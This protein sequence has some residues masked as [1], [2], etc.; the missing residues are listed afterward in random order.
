M[1]SEEQPQ[2][3]IHGDDTKPTLIYLPGVHGDWTLVS[4]FRERMKPHV[5]FVEFIYPR[6]LTWSLDDY[7]E[8]IL[9]VL[10]ENRIRRGVILGESYGSQ[11]AWPLLEKCREQHQDF[12]A[13][14]LILSGGFVRYPF[15]PF[16]DFTR[17]LWVLMPE[18]L[19]RFNFWLYATV[20]RWRHRNAPETALAIREFIARRT[21]EDLRAIDYRFKLIRENHPEQIASRAQVPVFQLTGFWDPVVHYPAVRRWLR[22][23]CPG[24]QE[25]HVIPAGDHNILGTAPDKAVDVM[26]HWIKSVAQTRAALEAESARA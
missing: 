9:R 18:K 19:I 17:L 26:E 10:K 11:V 12:S 21:P 13:D 4:S 7:A 8:A 3:R 16:V 1:P 5:R 25:T 14:A 15:M 20:A 6:T 2:I 24:Y 22:K 23:N